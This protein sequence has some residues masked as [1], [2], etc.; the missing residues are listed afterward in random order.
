M[1]NDNLIDI[2]YIDEKNNLYI[3]LNDDPNYLNVFVSSISPVRYNTIPRLFVTDTDRDNYPDI[4]TA[5]ANQN[6]IGI[7]FNR[8]LNYWEEV[9]QFFRANSRSKDIVY[10]KEKPWN[11]IPLYDVYE[12]KNIPDPGLLKDFTLFKTI[13]S[14]R[15]NFQLFALYTNKLIW[16]VEKEIKLPPGVEWG[17]HMMEQ[18]YMYCMIQCEIVIEKKKKELDYE[19]ILDIDVNNDEY[20]EFILYSSVSSS[21]YWIKKYIPY[22]TGFGWNSKF[23]IYLTLFIY[24]LSSIVGIVEF[25][26]LKR[27][28]DQM[29]QEKLL[30]EE[31]SSGV[32]LYTT[33][34]DNFLH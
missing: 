26:H 17:S 28:N 9:Q 31:H 27:L 22:L 23:W 7:L 5:D 11:F 33:G 10:Y 4:V 20:P 6:N 12:N 2:L 25:F 1:N 24:I 14:N 16:F 21:L 32:N 3:L 19:F 15:I 13:K 30:K 8:G 34:N 18:N 29:I